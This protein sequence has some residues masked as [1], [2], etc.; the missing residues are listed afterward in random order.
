MGLGWLQVL[1]I[2][3]LTAYRYCHGFLAYSTITSRCDNVR[4]KEDCCAAAVVQFEQVYFQHANSWIRQLASSEPR[5][6]W[7]LENVTFTWES[8]LVLLVG[9]SSSGKS[10]AL[11]LIMSASTDNQPMMMVPTHGAVHISTRPIYRDTFQNLAVSARN[12]HD[13][14]VSQRLAQRPTLVQA[15]SLESC[16]DK[17]LAQLSLS[18]QYKLALAEQLCMVGSKAEEPPI[19]LLDEWL[20]KEPTSIVTAVEDALQTFVAVTKG[21]VC[22]VTHKSDRWKTKNRMEL[23]RGKIV[24]RT[25]E[26]SKSIT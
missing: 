22:V 2:L 14:T 17:T 23:R 26:P 24:G 16:R 21:V 3:S 19:L 18:E 7:A 13:V 1:A 15:L 10:T 8:E 9:D 6:T 4:P 12:H 20:D 5:R 25:Y 11:Q